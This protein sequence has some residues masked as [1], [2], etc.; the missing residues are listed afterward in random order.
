MTTIKYVNVETGEVTERE[1]N[2]QELAQYETDKAAAQAQ[3]EAEATK[4][5]TKAAAT[6][7]L[8]ALGLTED[9]LKALGLGGN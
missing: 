9:D 2:A 1:M 3:R 7:K 6:A 8:A 5:A 4:A